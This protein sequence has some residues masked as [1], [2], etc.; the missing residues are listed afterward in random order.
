MADGYRAR[1]KWYCFK[2]YV[3]VVV[4]KKC[5]KTNDTKLELKRTR[6][7]TDSPFSS[8]YKHSSLVSLLTLKRT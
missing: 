6:E 2:E 4:F 7:L 8:C 1:W 5:F 3:V